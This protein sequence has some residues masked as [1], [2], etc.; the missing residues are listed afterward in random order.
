MRKLGPA[1]LLAAL[2]RIPAGSEAARTAR[3]VPAVLAVGPLEAV[4]EL[5]A[6]P[7]QDEAKQH[8]EEAEKSLEES[9]ENKK[10]VDQDGEKGGFKWDLS[11]KLN[12]V[13]ASIDLGSPPAFTRASPTGFTLEAPR[14]AG[15]D[16][17]L[18]GDVKG[19]A[20]VKVDGEKV[21]SW[22]P[23]LHF[24]LRIENFKLVAETA[25]DNTTPNRPKVGRSRVRPSPALVGAGF[26]PV[27]IPR[28]R[29]DC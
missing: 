4:N 11:L 19:R 7:W 13:K 16:F 21:F 22:S 1:L 8:A 14:G 20:S 12:D 15:W 26:L 9:L 24:G 6:V 29:T 28:H 2:L 3:S 5:I 23:G 18:S 17:A 10:L 27:S 25:L